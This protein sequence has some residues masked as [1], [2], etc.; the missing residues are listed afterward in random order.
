VE[1]TIAR[2]GVDVF[3]AAQRDLVRVASS[4]ALAVQK[5]IPDGDYV[6]WDYLDDDYVTKIPVRL[7]CRMIVRDGLVHLDFA[8]SDP[9]VAAAYNIPTAGKRHPW[10]TL[11][12]MHF[13]YSHDATVPLNPGLF[14]NITVSAPSGTVVN[15]EAPAAVGVRS[16]TA[17]RL[18]EVLV[19]ALACAR[20]GLMPAPSGGVMIPSVLVEQ[21]TSGGRRVI[22]LQSLVGGTG[23][24][25]GS[26]G[27]DGRDSSLANQRNTP[28][29]KTEEETAARIVDYSLRTDSGG[30]GEWRGG[31]GVCFSVEIVQPG[32][33]V[34]GRGME[35]F[36]FRPWGVA[37]GAPGERARVVVDMGTPREREI[38]K[39][40]MYLPRP[41][42]IVTIMTPGGGGYGDPLRRDPEMVREDVA[43]GYV[44]AASAEADYGVALR[45][46]TVDKGATAARR[47][48]LS[49]ERGSAIGF[50]FGPERDAWDSVFDDAATCELVALLLRLPSAR[51]SERRRAIYEAVI[52]GISERGAAMA[53]DDVSAARAR[54][55]AEM[56]ALA[57]ECGVT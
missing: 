21:D 50:S 18:N 32:S 16:A 5:K 24:R 39:L 37:G 4:K 45:D 6:F 22:V 29:E 34:L 46:G 38:G 8:G 25:A 52:P 51:R 44:S 35:R 14:E 30:A 19:G 55:R 10:F 40:D 11:K 33:A 1:E 20:P 3:V 13:I 26:D 27:V 17:I 23:A 43:L 49:A 31:T 9:Q 42:E 47:T 36:V 2:Y 48:S 54:L 15:P 57:L 28:I 56:N 53:I 41:G 7:R 12:L